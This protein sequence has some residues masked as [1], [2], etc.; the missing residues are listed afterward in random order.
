MPSLA[1]RRSTGGASSSFRITLRVSQSL[2]DGF[3]ITNTATASS[4]TPETIPLNNTATVISTVVVP[5]TDLT[6]A[7]T[8]PATASPESFIEYTVVVTNDGP[9]PADG[10]EIRDANPPHAGLGAVTNLTG[11]A[12]WHCNAGG[13]L[14][15]C[16]TVDPMPSGEKTIF[17]FR[18]TTSTF[19]HDGDLITNTA[20]V[21]SAAIPDSNP[22][23]NR[24]TVV[25]TGVVPKAD[26]SIT[27]TGPAI[28][29][30]NGF[31]D[32]TLVLTNNGSV[33]ADQVELRDATP[34]DTS[35]PLVTSLSGFTRFHCSAAASG[36]ICR[37][38]DGDPHAERRKHHLW[39]QILRRSGPA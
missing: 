32:Y 13:A 5:K 23:N 34:I 39:G 26:L 19:L 1:R 2:A 28:V 12:R 4:T 29:S 31:V 17:G 27:K 7:M 36:V 25:S 16:R 18:F 24:A 30:S 33:A 37:S 9:N 14:I 3:P 10:V 22:N 15:F 21:E 6:I 38:T 8:G 35:S 20:R 11:Y